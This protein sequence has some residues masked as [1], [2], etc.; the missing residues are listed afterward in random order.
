MGDDDAKSAVDSVFELA[1]SKRLRMAAE[2]GADLSLWEFRQLVRQ[3]P[4]KGLT[5]NQ[6]SNLY[7]TLDVLFKMV[8]SCNERRAIESLD[9]C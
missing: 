5:A 2:S 3:A 4:T 8:L 9:D 1:L 7:A 6:R